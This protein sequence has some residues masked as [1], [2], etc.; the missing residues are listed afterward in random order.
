MKISNNAL[1]FL[2]A[3]YRA[4][5][6][7]AYIKGIASAV[8]LTAGLAA[9]QAQA[10]DT[11]TDDKNFYVQDSTT[12]GDWSSHTPWY[13][14][15]QISGSVAGGYE[16]SDGT[17]SGSSDGVFDGTSDSNN[18]SLGTAGNNDALGTS[19]DAFGTFIQVSGDSSISS[20]SASSNKVHLNTGAIVGG[21][22]YG[23]HVKIDNGSASANENIVNINGGTTSSSAYGAY[24][25]TANGTATASSNGLVFNVA[26]GAS[27]AV[28][29]A[30]SATDGIFGARIKT[31]DGNAFASGNYVDI[32]V[33]KAATALTL[34]NGGNGIVGALAE[35]T[36][37]VSVTGNRVNIT[38]EGENAKNLGTVYSIQGGFALNQTDGKEASTLTADSN[39]VTATRLDLTSTSGTF[40][41]GG[42]AMQDNNASGAATDLVARNNKVSLTNTNVINNATDVKAL[43]VIGNIAF[44]NPGANPPNNSQNSVS[45]IGDGTTDN[46]YVEGGNFSYT[47]ARGLGSGPLNP[48]SMIAGGFAETVSGGGN[49][50]AN[51][52]KATIKSIT[53]TNVNLYGGVATSDKSAEGDQVS[54]SQNTLSVDAITLKVDSGTAT[55]YNKNYIVGGIAALGDTVTKAAATA[56]NNTVA[57]TNSTYSKDNSEKLIEADI[58]GAIV[59][60]TTSG[61]AIT[62]NQN[63][64]TVDQGNNVKGSVY[65]AYSNYNGSF[66]GNTVNFNATL[67]AAKDAAQEINGVTIATGDSG[68]ST[69]KAELTLNNNT[70]TV[71]ANA[72]LTNTSIYAAKLGA[73]NAAN[74]ATTDLIHSGNNVIFNGTQIIDDDDGTADKYA[75]AG[76]D[77]QI[78]STAFIHVKNGT[79]NISGIADGA[80]V[81]SAKYYN[82]T[83]TVADGARIANA[84]TINVYNS[85]DVQGDDSLFAVSTGAEL[86]IDAGSAVAETVE[87]P[88]DAVTPE[89]ATLK[90]SQAGLTNYLTATKDLAYDLDGDAAQVKEAKDAAGAVTVTS[91]GTIDFK[92]TVLLSAFDFTSGGATAGKINVDTSIAANSGSY[93]KA[94]TVTVAHKLATNTTSAKKYGDLDALDN[95]SGVAI[96]ANTLN[97]GSTDLSSDRSAA[98][99]FGQ[100]TVKEEINFIAKT[101]GDNL[102]DEDDLIDADQKFN[103]GYH[104]TSKVIGSNY[105]LTNDQDAA[106]EYYT[107]LPGSINGVVT[108]ETKGTNKGELV[109]QDGDWTANDLVTVTS[110]GSITVGG[111]SAVKGELQDINGIVREPDATLSLADGLT[112]DV[113]KGGEAKVTADG[114]SGSVYQKPDADDFYGDN[115]YVAL[116]LTHGVEMK[117][118]DNGD[119]DG[120]AV[121]EAVS[122][123]V[124]LLNASDVNDMLAQN[125]ANGVNNTSGAF[126]N[127]SSGGELRVDG[128]ITA[129]FRDFDGSGDTN[130]FNLA[131]KNNTVGN[132]HVVSDETSGR[133]VADSLTIVNPHNDKVEDD[134]EYLETAKK[135]YLGGAVIVDDLEINDL[136][137]TNGENKPAGTNTYAS[138]VTIA[139]GG[140]LISH[141]LTSVNDKLILGDEGTSSAILY[142]ETDTVGAAGTVAVNK[143]EL[144]SDSEI[145]FA[146]GEWNAAATDFNLSGAGSKLIVGDDYDHDINGNPYYAT[147]TAGN[148]TMGADTYLHVAANGTASFNGANLAELTAPT[149][150]NDEA[151]ILVEGYLTI[152]GT[153]ISDTNTNGGV[154]FGEE[155]SIRIANNGTLNFGNAAVNGAI[156]ADGQHSGDTVT[157]RDGDYTKIENIGGTLR[158]DFASG[159]S[160]STDAVQ[161]LKTKLFTDDSFNSDGVLAAG[162]MLNLGS[163]TFGKF[164]GYTAVNNPEE[165]LSGWTASW[166]DVKQ[167]SDLMNEIEDVT[168]DQMSQSNITG[169]NPGDEV[170]GGWG[171][172]SMVSNVPST[173]QVTLAG[174]TTLSFAEGNN[175][176]FISDE[177]HDNALGAIVGAQKAFNLVNGGK[178]GKVTL[179]N[180]KDDANDE[181]NLTTL[182]INGNGNLTTINGIDTLIGSGDTTA[183]NTRVN[184]N[185]DADVTGDITGVGRVYV[186]AGATLHVYNPDDTSKDVPEVLVNTLAVRNGTAQIDG[187][188]IINKQ[189]SQTDEG[190]G[191]DGEA[192]AIGGKIAATNIELEHNADLTT[193]HSGLISAETLTAV[194]ANNGKSDSLIAVGNDLDY[195]T[196]DDAE[197]TSY[198]GTG[199]LEV[200]KYLDLNGGTLMVDPAYGEATS[201]AAVMNFKDGS[202][203]TWDS[204]TNDVGIIDGKALIGKNAALGI[205]A[206]LA[207]TREA[208]ADFQENG[209][210]SQEKYGSILYLNGQ[211]TIA[212]GSE[213][214]L[215]ADP[216]TSDVDGIRRALKYTITSNKLDQFATLGLGA[217][218]AILMSEAAFEDAD[219][220]KTGTAIHFDRDAA[221][222]NANGGEIVLIGAFDA[223]EKLNFFSDN[224]NGDQNGVDIVNASGADGTIKV[225]TQ[226]G[227]LFA[228]LKGKNQGQDVQL[229][230][231]EEKAFS[232]M[233]E[234][235]YPVV[236]TLISYHEDRLAPDSSDTGAN[237]GTG[238]DTGSN[239]GTDSGAGTVAWTEIKDNATKTAQ[240]ETKAGDTTDL[241]K[242]EPQTNNDQTN[243]A[244]ATK[245]TGSSSFLNEV[246]TASHGA[247][248]EQAARLAV[249]GGAAQVGLAAAN[250]NSDILESRFGIGANA[251]SLNVAQ[252]GMGGTLWVAPIY[253]SQ[254]S[255]G[256][257]AQGLDYG[258]DFDLYGVALGG[259]YK[260]TNEITV[261]A[262]FNVGSGSLD[263]QGNTAAA[264][265]SNDFDYFGFALYGAYQAGA[266]TVTGDLSY[267]QIDNDLEGSN[268]VGKLTASSDTSAWSLGVTGQYQFTFA[269]VDVTPHAGL[270]FTSLDLD[271]YSL[272]AA[273]HGTVANYDGDTMSV[274]SIPVGVT[275]AKSFEGESWTVTPAL[276]L[277]VTGQFGDDE[278]EGSVAW[279]GTNLSTSVTSEVF[280]NFTYGATLGVEAQSN[281]FSFGVGLGYTGSSNADEFSA[282]ANARFT[283]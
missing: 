281:S 211:L 50:V 131:G 162:G 233:S 54:A 144:A 62:A 39:S 152:N 45:A 6:K 257:D 124:V 76:D 218:T 254:D 56:S 267:T 268:E 246:V 25:E 221:V 223:S 1:N 143:I 109:I 29:A 37:S 65:G 91:G 230:V 232:V 118:A 151:G 51:L 147:L 219:G 48:N 154:T 265:T 260:V 179:T 42:R 164:T 133:L 125:H 187:D 89:K 9:G 213:I 183:Y 46:V 173:A 276:D 57:V 2:L 112:L 270:R 70:V 273:G 119:V 277:H 71:G 200:S 95:T 250:S 100:A 111:K 188:L 83:G 263:G 8:I 27:A 31:K 160:F 136:Q 271:D 113:T 108:I 210:L 59:S 177:G 10:A 122:G 110:G 145:D 140:A 186:N 161:D 242:V 220:K 60:T 279:T 96:V 13:T 165:G 40:I 259:D 104:L 106:N 194:A 30:S 195:E 141:S 123:G 167:D 153:A 180:G 92:D 236:Q 64:V 191:G 225:Y 120:K 203:K 238:S 26:S 126:L 184:V 245:V 196:W 226:N 209:S 82:G 212:D 222:I 107:S 103:D 58:A 84:D 94:G 163:A 207:E 44:A 128:D 217:N 182:N 178:I 87:A 93:F 172:L 175:G 78:T 69:D 266:M 205:G 14:T 90:I 67:K 5:F 35:G 227:F 275:F 282:Q 135:V 228:T 170:K 38:I 181:R 73:T 72:K 23:A 24:V 3:Q 201:V 86:K 127:A 214:A 79:L 234:A 137:Q 272:E 139:N 176:F 61:A 55:G 193:V 231:D 129:Q 199:Y 11:P 99:T 4:I 280:D 32:T 114:D 117:I 19:G 102:S 52:N 185:S 132:L 224:D 255:D 33:D 278:A 229:H 101:S 138:Q 262:M 80:A 190:F 115:R 239:A 28:Q 247:P 148:L 243:T 159:S 149:D 7:R 97:L 208:I 216:V 88:E 74:A 43:Q 18:L 261:G 53:G 269:S 156:L 105:M 77:V 130:G 85:L 235:S 192:Y 241:T 197:E 20:V 206:T 158:L 16:D 251:Q 81:A 36:D 252:N 22:A 34:G 189:N 256:F 66:T 150:A 264:G 157:L 202:D 49:A 121:I 240:A 12:A 215:N 134:A 68:T 258:V 116:D 174:N 168:T 249:Y 17:N 41:F 198:T 142:F 98:I 283:F 237:N 244:P 21:S 15:S 274:F 146:N 166:D 253:K 47:T 75:L 169:I 204:V 63:S 155:G 248:A 171:S